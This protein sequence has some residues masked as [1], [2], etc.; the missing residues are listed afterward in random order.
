MTIQKTAV[1]GTGTMGSQ[2]AAQLA[3][4]GAEVV[5]L[6][7]VPNGVN[8]RSKLAK[9]SLEKMKQSGH[10]FTHPNHARQITPGNLEDDLEQL[11]KVDWIVEAVVEDLAIKQALYS[12]INGHRKK[13][14][15]LSSNTS[16]LPLKQ[17]KQGLPEDLQAHLCITH[18]FNPP[19]QMRLVE[20]VA[21]ETNANKQL[22]AVRHF[23]EQDMGKTIIPVKDTP[24]F[25]ANR[26]GIFWMMWGLEQ[27]LK[28]NIPVELADA[29]LGKPLGFP[30]TGIFKLMDLIGL[31]L[32]L[33][34]TKSLQSHLP[35]NDPY[36]QL[37]Q[38]VNLLQQMVE[39]EQTGNKG[40]GGFYRESNGGRQVI[41]F[42]KKSYRA[43]QQ[44]DDKAIDVAKSKSLQTV[45]ETDSRG[46]RYVR[47]VLAE[48]LH[49]SVSLIPQITEDI[50]FMDTAL[51]LGFNWHQGPL[52]MIDG[53]GNQ[54]ISGANWF[55]QMLKE[56]GK[57]VPET[58]KKAAKAGG[59]YKEEGRDL[60]YL[61]CDATYQIIQVPSDAWQL[62]D[63]IRGTSPV[64]ENRAA[65]LWDVG[66]GIACLQLITPF[67]VMDNATFDLVEETIEKVQSN[68]QGLM[69]GDDDRQFSAGLNLKKVLK[70]CEAEEWRA[71]E[72]ILERGQQSWM[73]LKYASFP[74]VCCAYGKALGGACELMLHADCIQAHIESHIGLV[75]VRIGLVPSWGGCKEMLMHHLTNVTDTGSKLQAI[76][77]VFSYIA[78]GRPSASSEEAKEW[79]ILRDCC[80]ITMNRVQVLAHAKRL[81]LQKAQNYT[82]PQ[83][84]MLELP[85]RAAKYVLTNEIERRVKNGSLNRHTKRVLQSLAFILSGGDSSPEIIQQLELEAIEERQDDSD[86]P[87]AIS[88]QTLLDLERK[89]FMALIKSQETQTKIKGIL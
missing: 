8:D 50:T 22:K 70:W 2:I 46:G 86:V 62:A 80:N 37:E 81:C 79:R 68:F 61:A 17:L 78:D 66:D 9:E 7:I 38:S 25:I 18:F 44:P 36:Q 10:A 55:I 1:I 67:D 13:G 74:V 72:A 71:I 30:K 54:R 4:G 3:N 51:T 11:S 59:F 60:Y 28:Q 64:I 83:N 82:P 14:A 52:A 58:L 33:D 57:A 65:K 27:T 39:H 31:D 19:R 63:I 32:M 87:A 53:L 23:I 40:D 29:L 89:A 20:L 45:L 21:D 88:E 47:S 84:R 26:I 48:T 73:A 69:I 49:Y 41:D 42:Q 24:G 43:L 77:Q 85:K 16:T 15:I 6:D 76:Q 34:I 12:K 75:E 56:D 35:E 5:L